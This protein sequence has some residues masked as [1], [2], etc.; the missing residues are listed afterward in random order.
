MPLLG[1]AV[2][3]G[4]PVVRAT[5]TGSGPATGHYAG[6]GGDVDAEQR[7]LLDAGYRSPAAAR[8]ELVCV[9]G[10]GADPVAAFSRPLP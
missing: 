8:I 5:R 10:S 7:G 6:P 4:V 3:A 9:L 1:D 2:R